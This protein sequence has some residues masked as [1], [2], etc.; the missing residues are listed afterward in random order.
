MPFVG[1]KCAF[2]NE[3]VYAHAHHMSEEPLIMGVYALELLI[4]ENLCSSLT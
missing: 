4:P 2:S 1:S 3:E